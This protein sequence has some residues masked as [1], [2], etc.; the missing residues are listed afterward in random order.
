M[1]D[2][3]NTVS[4]ANGLPKTP[5]L[6]FARTSN[7]SLEPLSPSGQ[8]LGSS[9][10]YSSFLPSE[11]VFNTMEGS[12]KLGDWQTV[13]RLKQTALDAAYA[14]I[15]AE[16]KAWEDE[17]ALLHDK[18][19]SLQVLLER[20][21]AQSKLRETPPAS[22]HGS[23]THSL[24]MIVE[25]EDMP[26]SNDLS[27]V[28]SIQRE[29]APTKIEISSASVVPGGDAQYEG[30]LLDGSASEQ[31]PFSPPPSVAPGLSPPPHKNR[32]C[33]GNTPLKPPAQAEEQDDADSD[34][35]GLSENVAD[36]T[37]T[38]KNTMHNLS[39]ASGNIS[40]ESGDRRLRGALNLPGLP[41]QAEDGTFTADML[42][43]KLQ[44]VAEHPDEN[45]PL[46]MSEQ[47][48][49]LYNPDEDENQEDN[50]NDSEPPQLSLSVPHSPASSSVCV[51]PDPAPLP[52][53][54]IPLKRKT[55]TNF[56]S[57]FGR[58]PNPRYR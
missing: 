53:N 11:Q 2:R 12:A 43:S 22:R 21:P 23:L 55:S 3:H 49:G 31:A 18:I 33:A 45:R 28:S 9:T 40:N 10:L 29:N 1:E 51:S 38:R 42:T 32:I 39:L 13:A 5:P 56:G 27:R 41:N 20:A 30:S 52:E 34:A 44:D 54:N 16:R 7:D 17:R 37:P 15:N 35:S 36:S 46:V 48:P 24:P 4:T 6:A 26:E 19:Q 50:V 8:P 58:P 47:S 25:D 14:A 57:G